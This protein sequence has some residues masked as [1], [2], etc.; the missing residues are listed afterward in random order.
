MY[1]IE[2]S[3]N[4]EEQLLKLPKE[5]QFRIIDVLERI[6]I[7]P[8]HFVKRLSGENYFR[9]RVGKYRIILDI[10]ND[11]LIIYVIEMGLRSNIY[12]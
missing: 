7:R 9:L 2:F 1:S 8:H 5:I 4:A 11:R 10:I 6:K 12:K 3:K